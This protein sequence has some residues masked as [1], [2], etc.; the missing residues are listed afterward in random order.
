MGFAWGV[1]LTGR[2][3]RYNQ[4][5]DIM[6][7]FKTKSIDTPGVIMRVKELFR[8]RPALVL[9]FNNFLPPGYKISLGQIEEVSA[10]V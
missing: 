9:G 10:R 6:K 2:V 3:C 4:F 5:L 1:Q 8:G 7:E